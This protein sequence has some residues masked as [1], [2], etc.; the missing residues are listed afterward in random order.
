MAPIIVHIPDEWGPHPHP[1][2]PQSEDKTSTNYTQ[3]CIVTMVIYAQTTQDLLKKS[4][5]HL[6]IGANPSCPYCSDMTLLVRF[7]F[8]S[9]SA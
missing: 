3:F 8:K 2:N 6:Y 5:Q 4:S 9:V 7:D 1:S